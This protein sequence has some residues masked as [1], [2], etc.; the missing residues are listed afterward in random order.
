MSYGLMY[1]N[2]ERRHKLNIKDLLDNIIKDRV[3]PPVWH[4]MKEGSVM[5]KTI[6][7]CIKLVLEE[8][9]CKEIFYFTE[10]EVPKLWIVLEEDNFETN[11]KITK[12]IEESVSFNS[13]EVEYMFFD[14]DEIDEIIDQL[15]MYNIEAV[16]MS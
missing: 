7:R 10:D 9:I 5:E 1:K 3:A 15:Q 12:I 14:E 8:D 13:I 6:D 11:M 16:R 2:F 4:T